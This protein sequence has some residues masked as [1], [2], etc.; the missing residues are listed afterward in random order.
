MLKCF[1]FFCVIVFADA[2][3][4]FESL[5]HFLKTGMRTENSVNS[6]KFWAS[7]TY[8]LL[9]IESPKDNANNYTE[10]FS[11]YGYKGHCEKQLWEKRT[12]IAK[13][14]TPGN[15]VIIYLSYSPCNCNRD[16]PE[17]TGCVEYLIRLAR[18]WQTNLIVHFAQLY[19]V[20]YRYVCNGPGRTN[21]IGLKRLNP[22]E[23]SP[24]TIECKVLEDWQGFYRHFIKWCR[25]APVDLPPSEPLKGLIDMLPDD[26][27]YDS[28]H[29][30][31]LK[32]V[33]RQ[34]EEYQN[35][36]QQN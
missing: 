10:M 18:V 7:G 3:D 31:K 16:D 8:L 4:S 19:K 13:H 22:G 12:E 20:Q 30:E 35:I 23:T 11:T 5:K 24:F 29:E 21:R 36:L 2:E 34:K 27:K 33:A 25:D 6:P 9:C 28:L 17:E 14:I 32:H 15:N 1:G 26:E